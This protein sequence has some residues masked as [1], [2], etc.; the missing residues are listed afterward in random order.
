MK[1]LVLY[2]NPQSR[3]R[4]AHWMMEELA[5]PYET[6]WLD[7][8][9]SM[10]AP[11]YLAINPMGKVPALKHGKA[12][13]TE[14]AAI[15][16]YLATQFPEKQLM[17]AHAEGQAAFFRWLFFAAGPLEQAV[18]AKSQNW[19]VT[20]EQEG[21][22]GFGNYNKTISTLANALQL[23]PYI[24]GE[25]FS[26]ADVYVGSHLSWGMLF[27][28]I[29]AQPVFEDYVARLKLRPAF[30]RSNQ[31]NDQYMQSQKA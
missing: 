3:G 2:T 7:Y 22:L 12:V 23:S 21:F 15:C 19:S 27:N 16:A 11:E 13:V 6:V 17:P 30:I 31:I 20:P 29:E 1:N 9:T 26:A 10:H 8:T 5:E 28:S 25:K 18:T 14:T 4:I 24:A